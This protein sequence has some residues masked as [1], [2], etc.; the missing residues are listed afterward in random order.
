MEPCP[1]WRRLFKDLTQ[2][3]ELTSEGIFVDYDEQNMTK[4]HAII[5]GPDG[6]PYEGGIFRF[7]MTIPQ[8]YP[9]HSPK[10]KFLTTDGGRVRFNP[11]LYD[12][13]KVCLSILGTWEGP[14]W[15]PA[16]SINSV[17][18]S[19]RSL[20]CEEPFYNEPGYDYGKHKRESKLYNEMTR[21]ET[22][23]VAII[24]E[25]RSLLAAD[26]Q[27]NDKTLLADGNVVGYSES[28][29]QFVMNTMKKKE[30]FVKES[31]EQSKG[32]RVASGATPQLDTIVPS[33]AEVSVPRTHLAGRRRLVSV[34]DTD[35]DQLFKMLDERLLSAAE[36]S[37]AQT[38]EDEDDI[39]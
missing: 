17:L 13:G 4:L 23:Q 16:M 35:V 36:T 28:A 18:L 39:Y 8:S 27:G 9:H 15:T 34:D 7:L 11:N 33:T 5:I 14:G 31:V 25:L 3:R 22:L 26:K 19:I 12:D 10:V 38:T 24:G 29:T 2:A 1:K 21:K 37:E 30:K 20:L 32:K 6:T